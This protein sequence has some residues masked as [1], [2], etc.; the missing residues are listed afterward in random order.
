M[1]T[2]GVSRTAVRVCPNGAARGWS[3]RYV[4]QSVMMGLWLG[5]RNA[6]RGAMRGVQMIVR[7]LRM[8]GSA[9]EGMR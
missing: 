8:D 2:W 7:G 1:T 9:R 6:M 3:H 4:S 5:A